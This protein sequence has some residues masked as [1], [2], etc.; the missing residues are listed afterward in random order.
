MNDLNFSKDVSIEYPLY[1]SKKGLYFIGQTPTIS[2]ANSQSIAALV[3]PT[4]SSVSIYL[5][6]LTVTNTSNLTLTAT[7]FLRA[8]APGSAASTFVSCTN[9]SICPSPQPCGQIQYSNTVTTAPAVGVP[10]FTRVIPG[11]STTVIDGGQIIIPPN[12]SILV[13]VNGLQS[14]S[15]DNVIVAF[16]WWEEM[17][18]N[19][20]Y[21]PCFC[22]N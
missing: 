19:C 7:V 21:N 17:I 4:N 11:I 5:N 13:Y 20:Y 9:V 22:C 3:N 6:S 15:A 1:Q 16:G 14:T 8:I 2:S 12:S 10:I 18:N